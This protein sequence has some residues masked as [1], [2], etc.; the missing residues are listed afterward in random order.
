MQVVQ[1][2]LEE[3]GAVAQLERR[4]G[5]S[6]AALG[7]AAEELVTL[8]SLNFGS[9]RERDEGVQ[10]MMSQLHDRVRFAGMEFCHI[11][12][13]GIMLAVFKAQWWLW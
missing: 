1:Q 10:A 12:Q 13:F 8:R 7:A 5:E 2:L 4:L 6:E 11:R 9:G 3:Q